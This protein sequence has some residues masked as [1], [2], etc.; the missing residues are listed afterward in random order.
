[1]D[2]HGR[3]RRFGWWV[4]ACALVAGSAAAQPV[5]LAKS[6]DLDHDEVVAILSADSLGNR[7]AVGSGVLIHPQVVLTAGH[8]NRDAA[9]FWG[10][11][12]A[13]G[14]IAV[15]PDAWNPR[16]RVEFR[17][18]ED[19]EIHP[20]QEAFQRVLRDSSGAST[21]DHLSDVAL[22]FLEQP[23]DDV[24]VARLA[25]PWLLSSNP[26][27]PPAIGVGFGYTM[28]IDSTMLS[29]RRLFQKRVDG[30]RRRWAPA[31]IEVETRWVGAPCDDQSGRPF[32]GMFDSGGPLFVGGSTVA[33]LWSLAWEKTESCP[34][35]SWATRVDTP[36][37]L[38]WI[39]EKVKT[40]MQIDLE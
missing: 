12:G 23:L 37:I 26:S 32:I 20:D 40:R 3:F 1:M 19:M 38:A 5:P 7:I 30:L 34:Y 2:A 36:E 11:T 24:P 13:F 8:V 15:G 14:T 6:I 16:V 21:V 4:C 25:S 10:G 33:G 29:D 28:S 17:W 27:T 39:R 35:T 22:V 9:K 18:L 31:R